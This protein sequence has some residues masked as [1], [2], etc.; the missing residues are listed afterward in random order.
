M[1]HGEAATYDQRVHECSPAFRVVEQ[2]KDK[3]DGS[4][5][6]ENDDQLILE[7]L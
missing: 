2:G 7:L 3:G 1:W 5:T 4:G 6:K